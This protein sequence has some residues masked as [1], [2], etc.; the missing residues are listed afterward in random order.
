MTSTRRGPPPSDPFGDERVKTNPSGE[1]VIV[2]GFGEVAARLENK[3]DAVGADIGEVKE[4]L[5]AL[6]PWQ[7]SQQERMAKIEETVGEQGKAILEVT[8]WRE[9][10]T[11]AAAVVGILIAVVGALVL[12]RAADVSNAVE[13]LDERIRIEQAR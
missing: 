5:A 7:T 6:S 10:W 3:I 1:A 4:R 8:R 2:S 13:R 9:R 12:Q 11:G